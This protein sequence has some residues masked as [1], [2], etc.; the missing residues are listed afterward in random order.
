M[1]MGRA[2]GGDASWRHQAHRPVSLPLGGHGCSSQA[3]LPP[4][5]YPGLGPI[6]VREAAQPV[7]TALRW[8]PGTLTGVLHNSCHSFLITTHWSGY[9]YPQFSEKEMK[10]P[11]HKLTRYK[12]PWGGRRAGF[13]LRSETGSFTDTPQGRSLRGQL[14]PKE[15]HGYRKGR[16]R[17]S[18]DSEAPGWPF[19]ITKASV[20]PL[21][22]HTTTPPCVCVFPS[23]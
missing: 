15:E 21:S 19:E 8:A 22:R 12:A 11:K 18:R 23:S 10:A 7:T 20:K 1:P 9:Y 16:P 5:T 4:H 13:S 3:P 2:W 14:F 6:Q 17:Q